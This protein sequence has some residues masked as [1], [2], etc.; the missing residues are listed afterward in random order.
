MKLNQFQQAEVNSH[1]DAELL[2][3]IQA[4]SENFKKDEKNFKNGKFNTFSFYKKVGIV[5]AKAI[6][7]REGFDDK[8][9]QLNEKEAANYLWKSYSE[10]QGNEKE[11]KSYEELVMPFVDELIYQA[12]LRTRV[13]LDQENIMNDYWPFGQ[14]GGFCNSNK[15]KMMAQ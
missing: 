5:V 15:L 11:Y 13:P 10:N 8:Y 6:A 9:H 3:L 2:W 14:D 1:K 12:L 4:S 7:E